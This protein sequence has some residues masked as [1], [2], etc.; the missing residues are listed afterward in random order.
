MRKPE[1]LNRVLRRE[2]KAQSQIDYGAHH[3][4]MEDLVAASALLVREFKS[5]VWISPPEIYAGA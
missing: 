1:I 3:E 4:R 2:V 5:P